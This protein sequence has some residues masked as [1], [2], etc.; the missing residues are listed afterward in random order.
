MAF[1]DLRENLKNQFEQLGERI[2]NSRLYGILNERYEN[3]TATQQKLAKIIGF[4]LV[5]GFFIYIPMDYFLISFE[6]ESSFEEK[7]KLIK[8]IIKSEREISA[9]PDLPRPLPAESIKS[10]VESQLKELNFLPEQIKQ[11]NINH[12]PSTSGLIPQNKIQYGIDITINKINVKQLTNL[13][14]KLQIIHPSVKLKDLI[15]TL[16]GEDSRYLNAEIKMVA[17]NI[18]EY[19]IPEPPPPENPKKRGKKAASPA[20]GE[21]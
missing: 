10:N 12:Q 8:D 18:P 11:V 21:E 4:L 14:A 17:L 7:R 9:L 6:N 13:G 20:E 16:N 19:K 5:L 1:E 2:T 15:V 3:L